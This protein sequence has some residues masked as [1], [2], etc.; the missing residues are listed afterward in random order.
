MPRE[1]YKDLT[2]TFNAGTPEE[3]KQSILVEETVY[4]TL[5]NKVEVFKKGGSFYYTQGKPNIT[6]LTYRAP[7]RWS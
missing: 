5:E 6:G 3:Y 1:W 7:T 4:N 2:T